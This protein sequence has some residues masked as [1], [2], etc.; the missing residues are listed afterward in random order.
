MMRDKSGSL[1]TL[2]SAHPVVIELGCGA[3]RR[4]QGSITIDALDH[5]CVDVVGDV[6][7]VFRAFPDGSVAHCT[8]SHFVEHLPDLG[9]FL[10]EL[11]RIT[12]PDATVEI[13]VPHFANPYFHSDP[14]HERT[15]GLYTMSYY[16]I[17]EILHRKVP[18]YGHTPHFK[19]EHVK[20]RFDS[21]FG[22]R[23]RLLKPLDR[24]INMSPRLQELHE[25]SFCWLV[26][27]HELEF[28]LRRVP[29]PRS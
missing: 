13:I 12:A 21:P 18:N 5:P 29:R 25:S 11:A 15:F 7:E 19:I 8:S 10:D 14:T 26:P 20:M 28:M 9:T 23:R 4:L 2:S 16:A 1:R 6:F 17:D 3:H 24:V 22:W 27:C